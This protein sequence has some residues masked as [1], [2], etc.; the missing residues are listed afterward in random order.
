L[1]NTHSRSAS[2]LVG[3]FALALFSLWQVFAAAL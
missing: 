3:I 2:A 1:I